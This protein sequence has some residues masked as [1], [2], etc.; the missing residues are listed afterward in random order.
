MRLDPFVRG[1]G[2][3]DRLSPRGVAGSGGLGNSSPCAGRAG[4]RGSAAPG[5]G[6][7]TRGLGEGRPNLLDRLGFGPRPA[8]PPPPNPPG[9]GT[10]RAS[11]PGL[12][13][14]RA[15]GRVHRPN[16]AGTR[17]P[18]SIRG[19]FGA[20]PQGS[21]QFAI[22]WTRSGRFRPIKAPKSHREPRTLPGTERKPRSGLSL[23][24]TSGPGRPERRTRTRALPIPEQTHLSWL[25]LRA[26]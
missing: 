20:A 9:R 1:S 24:R 11:G 8:L 18:G 16:R 19:L 17:G 21:E 4:P 10:A 3:A 15:G 13:W 6:T 25:T 26:C 23:V 14:S 12:A 22:Q 5:A 7:G 2:P